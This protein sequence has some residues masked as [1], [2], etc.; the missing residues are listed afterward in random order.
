MEY[1]E[2][3]ILLWQLYKL[4]T[5]TITKT[6]VWQ[7]WRKKAVKDKRN[8]LVI[9]CHFHITNVCIFRLQNIHTIIISYDFFGCLTKIENRLFSQP[10]WLDQI[11]LYS[12]KHRL[13]EEGNNSS[14]LLYAVSSALSMIIQ[15]EWRW[16][17]ILDVKIHC[18]QPHTH[19]VG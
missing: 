13:P 5:L 16:M 8:A 2:K 9:S 17:C 10:Q 1:G 4:H 7:N 6:G 3:I 18:L 12:R 15:Q 11:E 19:K 14:P